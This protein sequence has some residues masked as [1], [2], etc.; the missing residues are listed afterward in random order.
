MQL[1]INVEHVCAT[2]MW[3]KKSALMH[4]SQI[5]DKMLS[6]V[7]NQAARYPLVPRGDATSLL[8]IPLSP[9]DLKP[10]GLDAQQTL[11]LY[12]HVRV[13]YH[14]AQTIAIIVITVSQFARASPPMSSLPMSAPPLP[15]TASAAF[16]APV[17][18]TNAPTSRKIGAP[19]MAPSPPTSA[20]P[21]PLFSAASLPILSG[22]PSLTTI[23]EIYIPTL[24]HVPKLVRDG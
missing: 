6:V 14:G 12:H 5:W 2:E 20:P 23:F 17:F 19:A 9:D 1:F 15:L 13:S 24:Q 11:L 18:F 7:Q 3:R 8:F 10:S 4:T 22:L 16:A 21:L